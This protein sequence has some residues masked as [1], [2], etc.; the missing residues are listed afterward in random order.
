MP[1]MSSKITLNA[2]QVGYTPDLNVWYSTL[3]LP[4]GR[5]LEGPEQITREAAVHTAIEAFHCRTF[6]EP[7]PEHMALM[8]QLTFDLMHAVNETVWHQEHLIEE[9][10]QANPILS[11]MSN[12]VAERVISIFCALQHIVIKASEF[13]AQMRAIASDPYAGAMLAHPLW[14]MAE[15]KINA[16]VR[17]AI[18]I[19][20]EMG[21]ADSLGG[22]VEKGSYFLNPKNLDC[23]WPSAMASEWWQNR[24]SRLELLVSRLVIPTRSAPPLGK[25]IQNAVASIQAALEVSLIEKSL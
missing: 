9:I 20:D 19:A 4:C 12:A 21:C 11:D 18:T 16:A 5:R 13:R 17:S 14:E 1:K 25:E 6:A 10:T 7:F 2:H 8:T 23:D 24:E 22:D 15:L 3:T